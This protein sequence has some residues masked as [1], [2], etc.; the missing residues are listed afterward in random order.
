MSAAAQ[1]HPGDGPALDAPAGIGLHS[2]GRAL[3]R[4]LVRPYRRQIAGVLLIVLGQV[5]ATMAAPWLIGIAIDESLPA[6]RRGDYSSLRI[7]GTLLLVSAVLSGTLR[8]VFVVRSGTIGQA[9][10]F[11]LRRKGFDHVQSLSV[12]F[13]ERF[14]SGRVISRLT[15]DVDT[16]TELLDSGLD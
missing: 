12:A 14:T 1:Q 2:Q 9:I 13:H 5:S 6:A 16:L 8:A 3:L 4:E 15:S 11:D 7:V 10:L